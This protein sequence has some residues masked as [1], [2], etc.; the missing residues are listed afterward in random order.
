MYIAFSPLTS[1]T[2]CRHKVTYLVTTSASLSPLVFLLLL[3]C[4]PPELIA[5]HLLFSILD[6]FYYRRIGVLILSRNR[7]RNGDQ[8]NLTLLLIR[9]TIAAAE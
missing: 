4:Q 9:P 8:P 3:P 7:I 2:E 5:S 1:E 6:Q